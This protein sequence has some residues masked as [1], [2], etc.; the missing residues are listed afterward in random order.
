M[1]KWKRKVD[2]DTQRGRER[3]GRPKREAKR[4]MC[5]RPKRK[6]EAGSHTR[7]RETKQGKKRL[8]KRAKEGASGW[9]GRTL[10]KRPGQYF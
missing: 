7:H 2:E 8:K 5:S 4:G 6:E 9:P 3:K 1:G 10:R